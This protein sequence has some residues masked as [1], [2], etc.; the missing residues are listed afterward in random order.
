M[1]S[2][3]NELAMNSKPEHMYLRNE[4]NCEKEVHF[5]DKLSHDLPKIGSKTVNKS[6]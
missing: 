1:L 5:H 4:Q 2:R 3:L 6:F